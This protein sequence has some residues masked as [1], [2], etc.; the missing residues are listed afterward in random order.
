MSV[1]NRPKISAQ[2]DIRPFDIR[3][4]LCI[5]WTESCGKISDHPKCTKSGFGNNGTPEHSWRPVYN[6]AGDDYHTSAMIF[7][8]DNCGWCVEY[9]EPKNCRMGGDK[10]LAYFERYDHI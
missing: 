8:C 7:T 5:S 4:F 6:Y 1:W 10:I 9:R 3:K 2:P